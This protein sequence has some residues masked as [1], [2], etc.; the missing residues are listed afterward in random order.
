MAVAASTPSVEVR[1]LLEDWA[2]QG[3]GAAAVALAA[4]GGA[5]QVHAAGAASADDR[6]VD[7]DSGFRI[8][9]L[10]K[11]FVA[12]MVLQALD[13]QDIGLDTAVADLVAV[14]ADGVT[15]R[16]LLSHRS[17]LP[18]HTD[19]ELAPAVL[20]EPDRKWTATDVMALVEDQPLEFEP[21]ARFAYS[22]T[23][24]IVTGLLLEKLTGSSVA[25]NLRTR[26]VEPLAMTGTYFPPDPS[27]HPVTGFSRSLPGGT[28]DASAYTA[29]ETAA[30]AAGGMVSTAGDVATFIQALGDGELLPPDVY[31]EM[32]AD[33]DGP[34]GAG[35]GV[36]AAD[37]PSP[38]G[39]SNA[40]A[41]PGFV[42]FMQYDPATG[43]V[44]VLLVSDD[45]RSVEPLGAG[46]QDLLEAG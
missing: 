32:V 14:D 11:T 46:L 27:R 9:S 36:F 6:D 19:G 24:Y 28:S 4:S 30:G 37:P 34:D 23:N 22:N 33:I 20:A 12:V 8:G 2:A 35:L 44:L 17:G 45:S 42:S 31:R 25:E 21:G 16:Q 41:I 3:D 38:T 10:T 1:G 39:I 13:E 7:E 29:L 43:D 18:E 26:L 15:I 40:G 5:V